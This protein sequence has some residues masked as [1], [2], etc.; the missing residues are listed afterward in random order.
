MQDNEDLYQIL[1]VDPAASQ[2]EIRAAHE[3][4]ASE[5]RS[6]GWESREGDETVRRLDQA[7][8][9]LS[10]PVRRSEYDRSRAPSSQAPDADALTSLPSDTGRR[11]IG[12]RL[13]DVAGTDNPGRRLQMFGWV[14]A[15]ILLGGIIA[16]FLVNH[17]EFGSTD[18]LPVGKTEKGDN[19]VIRLDDIER[20]EEVRY[21]GNDGNHYLVRPQDSENELIVLRLIVQNPKATKLL[22]TIDEN[23]AELR[24]F[25]LDEKYKALDVIRRSVKVD[26]EAVSDEDRF[27]PFLWNPP[28]ESTELSQDFQVSGWL[29]FELPKGNKLKELRW[30]A[31]G[32][33]IY[34]RP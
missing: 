26:D 22:F 17:V 1:Q 12:N 31:A 21:K 9:V 29:V 33:V 13:R 11:R 27:V 34:I 32:D 4:L 3:R 2:E 15:V 18:P 30:E 10:D 28:G 19:L 25:G 20:V 14:V 24:G 5:H 23:A 16:W 6:E 7:F 8:E